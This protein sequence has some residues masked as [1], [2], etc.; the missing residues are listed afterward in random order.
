MSDSKTPLPPGTVAGW[1]RDGHERA[2]ARDGLRLTHAQ[3]LEWLERKMRELRA[4]LGAARKPS[5]RK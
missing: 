4:M 5:T 2:Q 3:R 1:T